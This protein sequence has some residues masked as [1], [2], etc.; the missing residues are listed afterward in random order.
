MFT[1]DTRL[2]FRQS[3]YTLS[4]VASLKK[5]VL[6]AAVGPHMG[7]QAIGVRGTSE[8]WDI[9]PGVLWALTVGRRL[10]GTKPAIPYFLIVGTL[11]GSST[12]TR[13]LSD[14]ETA[15]LHAVDTKIDLSLGW[16]LGEAFSPYL[17]VRGF[18]GPVFWRQEGASVIGGD[19]YHVSVACGFNLVLAS[20]VTAW[21]DGAFV[22]MRG[23]GGGVGVRF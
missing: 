6:G 10:F 9:R 17:S 7:G 22:G 3:A 16:T 8:R 12:S 21:F 1:N 23:L 19:L 18:G 15:G 4:F 2:R 13:R 5:I 20:R 14:G 11:S